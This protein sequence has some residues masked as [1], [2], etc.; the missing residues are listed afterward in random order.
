MIKNQPKRITHYQH[1]NGLRN[2]S[3]KKITCLLAFLGAINSMFCQS[4]EGYWD[5]VRVTTETLTL[6]PRE[7]IYIKTE[8]FPVGTTEIVYRITVLDDNQKLSSSLF[9]LLK[10]IPDPSGISQG[11]AGAVFL[12]SAIAGDDKCKYGIYTSERAAIKYTKDSKTDAS[13]FFQNTAIN[14]EAKLISTNTKCNLGKSN[15]LY[16]AFTSDNWIMKQKIILEVVPWINLKASKGWSSKAKQEVLDALKNTT[17]FQNSSKKNVLYAQF[18]NELTQK[19]SFTDFKL[20]LDIEK[21]LL[22]ENTFQ[23][24]LIKTGEIKTIQNQIRKQA[25][26]YFANNQIEQA[27]RLLETEI[28]EKQ[29]ATAADYGALGRYYLFTNQFS[30][31]LQALEQSERLDPALLATKLTLAHV[32]MFTNKLNEAKIIHKKYKNQNTTAST[33]WVDQTTAD[34]LDLQKKGF[35]T[36]NF[37]KI[38]S[39]L[40]N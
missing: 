3:M 14:K 10:S 33:T 6:S 40:A 39:I 24:V 29:Q 18:L 11:S 9:S 16:F 27:I 8:E 26:N 19:V 32:Y 20:L 2:I 36:E 4:T 31:A 17:D 12:L 5:N 13:C 38:R 21:T 35:T 7:R 23:A 34:F 28:I 15:H 1:N 25:E 37:K 22:I 30:K